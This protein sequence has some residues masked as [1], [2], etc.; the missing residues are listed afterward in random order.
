MAQGLFKKPVCQCAV[1][2]SFALKGASDVV[3]GFFTCE[4]GYVQL[5]VKTNRGFGEAANFREVIAP[6]GETYAVIQAINSK[7]LELIPEG[8]ACIYCARKI[9]EIVQEEHCSIKM[10]WFQ[11]AL[12]SIVQRVS[13]KSTARTQEKWRFAV[14]SEASHAH[15]VQ[16]PF[17]GLS[18]YALD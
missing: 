18:A 1:L 16:F 7:G 2:T 9:M 11:E 14:E 17:F 13:Q 4:W 6:G 5:V 15:S 3:V 12:P 8:E 10:G